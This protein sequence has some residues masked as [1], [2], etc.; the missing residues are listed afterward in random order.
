MQPPY[1]YISGNELVF[2]TLSPKIFFRK[3]PLFVDHLGI[4]VKPTP[5]LINLMGKILENEEIPPFPKKAITGMHMQPVNG[6][7]KPRCFTAS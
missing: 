2:N 1:I 3:G 5:F 7:L 4:S 6:G